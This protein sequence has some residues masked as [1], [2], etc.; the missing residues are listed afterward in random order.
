MVGLL[1]LLGFIAVIAAIAWYG[2]R[3]APNEGPALGHNSP[4]PS[5][6]PP[7]PFEVRIESEDAEGK[8]LEV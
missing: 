5:V 7:V 3:G 4:Y 2:W 1:I 6:L 8:A